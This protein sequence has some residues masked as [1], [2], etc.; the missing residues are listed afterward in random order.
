MPF[1]E[2]A[3]NG[4]RSIV[5]NTVVDSGVEG[6]P[7]ATVVVVDKS[8]DDLFA[9]AA[10]NRGLTSAD[11]MTLENIFWIASCTKMVT[12]LACMQLVEKGTLRL[13]DADQVESLCPELRAMKV[14][15]KDG[16][17][18]E[19]RKGITLRMLLSHTAGF[20][21]TF[22]NEELRNWSL[23][24]GLEDIDCTAEEIMSSPLTFQPGEGWQYGVNI[25]WA[26]IVLERQTG[27]SLNGYI[28][29]H[30]CE[31]LGLEN[32][33]MFPTPGMRANLAHMNQRDATGKLSARDHAARR[34][35]LASTDEQKKACFNS[36]GAGLF[37]KPQEYA[38]LLA[39]LLNDGT[40]PKTGAKLLEKSTVDEMFR[41]QIPEFPDFGRQG[42]PAAKPHYTN[43]IPDLYPLPDR[44]PQGW[45]LSFM[46]TGG[47]TGRSK[48][49]GWWAGLPNLFWWCDR[50]KGVAGIVCSQVLPFLD[51]AVVGMWVEL[52][53]AVYQ[54]LAA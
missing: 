31:P 15:R 19:K 53:T 40:C 52:E 28:Q 12:A 6:L 14:L 35:L 9:Y 27:M 41:N 7:G 20:G 46:L 2:Q 8:G 11:P 4:L 10:G 45:G 16:S 34:P 21:Y 38:R 22:F 54:A 39:V 44:A 43:P 47:L 30:I 51:P 37:A 24:V 25:D 17:F 23:P 26:G 18:E 42:I 49:T 33:N 29:K 36:G 48:S 3:I 5:D 32:I 50:E 13:D 1:S